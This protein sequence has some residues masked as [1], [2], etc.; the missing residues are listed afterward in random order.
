MAIPEVAVSFRLSALSKNIEMNEQKFRKLDV[1][2]KAIKQVV[3][4][5]KTSILIIDKNN[6]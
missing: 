5:S 1:W 4:A 2:S 3:C 6:E